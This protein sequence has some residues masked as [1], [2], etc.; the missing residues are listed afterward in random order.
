M[1]GT[2]VENSLMDLWTLMDV[3]WPG[4]IGYSA[5][6][7]RKKF[8]GEE[9]TEVNFLKRLMTEP[10]KDGD[11]V[12]PQLML[13][14]M[15]SAVADLKKKHFMPVLKQMPEAQAEAYARACE[16]Q[17][18]Q[19]GAV[20]MSLQAIRNISLHPN[21]EARIDFSRPESVDRFIGMSARLVAMFEIL[22]EIK[23][24]DEKALVFIDLRRAQSIVAELIKYRYGLELLPHAINGETRAEQR[25]AIRRGFQK[26]RG[27]EVLIL[28]PRAAGFGLTLHSANHVVHLNRWWNPAVEDQCTDRAYRIGQDREVFVW[29]PIAEH[30]EFKAKSYDVLLNGKLEK[31]RATSYDVIVPV[32]FDAREMARLHSEIFGGN[33]L[34]EELAS[35]D[36]HRFE[37][38][39]C[40]QIRSSGLTVSKTPR[41]GDGGA[42]LI[43][44]V[45]SDHGR[46]A[47]VQVK[48]RSRGKTGLVS[49]NEVL[50]VIRAKDRY[51]VRDPLFFLVTNGSVDQKGMRAAELSLVRII[52]YSRVSKLADIVRSSLEVSRR[53]N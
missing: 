49:E 46:G 39:T 9:A 44:R 18:S 34:E 52:D 53:S 31:K 24:K 12:V 35:M 17:K 30:P 13:R 7:F 47:F 37:D 41:S 32:R 2:P 26:R 48:H 21:L 14:R 36:W 28:A 51:A 10:Q 19:P 5:K 11:I 20:L 33:F 3:M 15:K 27:F 29:I 45:S 43:V 38:W 25:D 6:E 23:A 22:D 42:D 40:D 8:V 16:R 1:T 50:D 4:R